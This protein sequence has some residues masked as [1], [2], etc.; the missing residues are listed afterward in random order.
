VVGAYELWW[1][2]YVSVDFYFPEGGRRH[3]DGGRQH[4]GGSN[5]GR[6]QLQRHCNSS[7]R[8][9]LHYRGFFMQSEVGI[10]RMLRGS[11]PVADSALQAKYGVEENRMREKHVWN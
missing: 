6:R 5:E 9:K 10:G 8:G 1:R 11:Y 3:Y 7:G 2:F 4:C